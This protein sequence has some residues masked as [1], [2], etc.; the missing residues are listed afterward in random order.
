[1][2]WESIDRMHSGAAPRRKQQHCPPRIEVDRHANSHCDL[3]DSR[4]IYCVHPTNIWQHQQQQQQQTRSHVPASSHANTI[5][6]THSQKV[7][8]A[9]KKLVTIIIY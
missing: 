4:R 5:G 6:R 8:V 3:D 9:P 1:M 7:S 2:H